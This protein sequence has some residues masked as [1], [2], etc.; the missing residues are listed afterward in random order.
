M[1]R[2]DIA[3]SSNRLDSWVPL[4]SLFEFPKLPWEIRKAAFIILGRFYGSTDACAGSALLI[5]SV[6]LGHVGSRKLWLSIL[7]CHRRFR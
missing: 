3:A 5:I 1:Q 6:S 4:H 2:R 7:L